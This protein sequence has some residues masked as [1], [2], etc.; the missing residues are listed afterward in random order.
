VSTESDR[1]KILR[2]VRSARYPEDRHTMI[3]LAVIRGLALVALAGL[4]LIAVL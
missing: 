3:G 4:V 1:R 2:D